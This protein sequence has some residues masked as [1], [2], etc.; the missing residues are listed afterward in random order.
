[1][2]GVTDL[3]YAYVRKKAA[4]EALRS[5]TL[6]ISDGEFVAIIG[7]NSSGKTTL[8]RH[9]NGLLT[10]SQGLVLVDGLDTRQPSDLLSI[11]RLVGMVLP[12]PDNQIV[13]TTVEEDVAFG[14][15]NLR[16]P[17]HLIK[18]RVDRSLELVG[19]SN[20]HRR[21]PHHLSNGQKQLLALAGVLAMRPKYIVFDEATSMLD[22]EMRKVVLRAAAELR[23]LHG[24]TIIWVTHQLDEA[25]QGDRVVVMKEGQIYLDAPSSHLLAHQES[26]EAIGLRLPPLV[27]LAAELRRLGMIDQTNDCS[28]EGIA[29]RLCG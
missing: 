16:I 3:H 7:P 19:L 22:A 27:A 6:S 14:L 17:S 1:M 4:V 26:L 28:A 13:G 11:R 21:N 29:N 24:K 15:E 10:P 8:A 2:I 18:R 5:V 9:L 20:Q 12:N 25:I 23:T